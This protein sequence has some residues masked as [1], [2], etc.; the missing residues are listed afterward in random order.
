MLLDLE[1]EDGAARQRLQGKGA[2]RFE[3]A[4]EAFL[5]RV[6]EGYL[7]LARSEPRVELVDAAGTSDA[8]H[9]K[10]KSLL[11]ARFPETFQPPER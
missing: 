6:R 8:V 7:S 10:L 5:R 1:I 4:G 11:Q 3:G 2:D 9:E